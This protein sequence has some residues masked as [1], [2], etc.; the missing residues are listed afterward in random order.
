MLDMSEISNSCPSLTLAL[1]GMVLR[2]RLIGPD[3]TFR[4]A[5]SGTLCS[6]KLELSASGVRDAPP[7]SSETLDPVFC[8]GSGGGIAAMSATGATTSRCRV[9]SLT[10]MQC[11]RRRSCLQ[12]SHS[13]DCLSR[14]D[15]FC[16]AGQISSASFAHFAC[17]QLGPSL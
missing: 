16:M 7:T 12:T 14:Q 15:R 1:C 13:S 2:L 11:R 3:A 17:P 10:T 8:F 4:C 9:S 6:R 5:P